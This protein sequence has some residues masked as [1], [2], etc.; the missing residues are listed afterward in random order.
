MISKN[1]FLLKLRF[2][3]CPGGVALGPFRTLF[4]APGTVV[5]QVFLPGGGI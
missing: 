3:F 2:L 1:R 4:F 5:L